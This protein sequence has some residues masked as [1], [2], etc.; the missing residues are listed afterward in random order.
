M[1]LAAGFDQQVVFE[2]L[3]TLLQHSGH[4]FSQPGLPSIGPNEFFIFSAV[5]F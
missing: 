3:A 2:S 4:L 1:C 5:P